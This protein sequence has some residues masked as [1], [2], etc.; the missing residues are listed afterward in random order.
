MDITSNALPITVR[1]YLAL[2]AK[3]KDTATQMA[4]LKMANGFILDETIGGEVICGMYSWNNGVGYASPRMG[5]ADN[6]RSGLQPTPTE[7]VEDYIEIMTGMGVCP[8]YTYLKCPHI[9]NWKY[10]QGLTGDLIRDTLNYIAGGKRLIS[11]SNFEYLM[12][13]DA[14]MFGADPIGFRQHT[15]GIKEDYKE[16]ENLS[17]A[18]FFTLWLSRSGG[19]QDIILSKQAIIEHRTIKPAE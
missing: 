12:Q 10:L 7:L 18:D 1:K 4:K 16:I 9:K 17:F 19:W 11:I 5:L 15:L 6:A 2:G 3:N 8:F 14:R 13:D